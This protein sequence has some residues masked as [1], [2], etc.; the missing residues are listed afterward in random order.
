MLVM[1]EPESLEGSVLRVVF[2]A[3]DGAFAVLRIKVKGRDEPVAVVGPLADSTPG[4]L[5]KLEGTWERHPTHG[6]QFRATRAVIEI[7]RTKGGVARYLE[8]LK[9][10]GPVVAERLVAA[11]CVDAIEGME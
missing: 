9:G 2:T 4:E 3:P 6:E 11:F 10:I 8:G 5:L 1:A 7:P